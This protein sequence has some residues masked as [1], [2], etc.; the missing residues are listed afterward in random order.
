LAALSGNV[1]AIG[2]LVQKGAQIDE[3]THELFEWTLTSEGKKITPQFIQDDHKVE[4]NKYGDYSCINGPCKSKDDPG[5]SVV[6]DAMRVE[7]FFH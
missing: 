4:I 3:S 5:V 1:G 6:G 7:K 2:K